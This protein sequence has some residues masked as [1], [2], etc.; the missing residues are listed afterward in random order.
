MNRGGINIF[1]RPTPLG[2]DSLGKLGLLLFVGLAI[3]P[4]AFSIGYAFAYS[5]GMIGLL[6]EGVT[7]KHWMALWQGSEIAASF[8]LSIYIAG[9][10]VLV[11]LTAAL[12]I[13][14]YLQK[15][16]EKGPLSYLIF[17]PLA[18]PAT[19]AAFLVFQL[20]SG[21]GYLTRLA[22]SMGL[23]EEVGQLPEMVNDAWGIGI[24]VAH[25]F[26]AVPFFV[27]LFQEIYNA[28]KVAQLSEL[29]RTLG[30]SSSQLL[31][32]V[33][34]PILLKRATT[35]II[36]MFISVLGSYEIPL[37]LGR[38]APQMVS[39]L[40]LRKYQMFDILE[41]PE[42]FVVALLYTTLVL[43]LIMLAFRFNREP[44]T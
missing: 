22:V 40:T 23:V 41:K 2:N 12:F 8:G 13:S 7:A 38:Q 28:E 42:A 20:L 6:S 31:Y 34:I 29:A 43:G 15:S 11:T 32:R 4:I 25:V 39:V 24:I 19:V 1:K 35:N 21:A 14:L 10:A 3:V 36:L 33:K 37:L 26:L 17:L 27:L 18:M 30:A 9:T 16:L 5:T 44:A